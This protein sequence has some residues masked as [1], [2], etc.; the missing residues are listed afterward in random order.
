MLSHPL[1]LLTSIFSPCK[2]LWF[3]LECKLIYSSLVDNTLNIFHNPL[4]IGP[5]FDGTST[6]RSTSIEFKSYHYYKVL[7]LTTSNNIHSTKLLPT[8]TACDVTTLDAGQ[9]TPTSVDSRY[10][11]DSVY[12]YTAAWPWLATL[13]RSAVQ[14]RQHRCDSCCDPGCLDI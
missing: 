9:Q 1:L 5:G 6:L 7:T 12:I 2:I 14:C 11:I 13:L 3:Q 4:D 8:H 10:C